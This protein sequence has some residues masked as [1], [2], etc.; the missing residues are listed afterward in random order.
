MSKGH[1]QLTPPITARGSVDSWPWTS[2]GQHSMV[3]G[4]LVSW[5]EGVSMEELVCCHGGDAKLF[6]PDHLKQTGQLVPGFWEW[7][8]WPRPFT[9]CSTLDLPSL[10]QH[11]RVGPSGMGTSKSGLKA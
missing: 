8:S 7:E 11:S 10:G 9:G 1:T 4:V 2:P 3:S 5:P 6:A